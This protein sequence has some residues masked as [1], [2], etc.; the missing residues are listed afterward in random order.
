MT[1]AACAVGPEG[2]VL[3]ADSTSTVSVAK[4]A[5]RY[6]HN[7]QK[8][9][10]VG[11]SS[12]FG[13][14][15]WGLGRIG[16]TSYRTLI[17]QLSDD[18]RRHPPASVEEAAAAFSEKI[19]SVYNATLA[20][21]IRKL[22][23]VIHA[24]NAKPDEA[25]PAKQTLQS[26]SVGFCLGGYSPAN[27]TPGAYQLDF[28]ADL[29]SAPTAK[30][31]PTFGFWGANLVIL[32]TLGFDM[33][34]ADDVLASNK[35]SGT[36]QELHAIFERHRMP[37]LQPVPMRE[38][39]DMIHALLHMTIKVMKFTSVPPVC[40]GHIEIAT[41]TTDRAFRWVKHKSLGAALEHP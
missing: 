8:V 11:E 39:I 23:A 18:F 10:E 9:F 2:I 29:T 25:E 21:E 20:P 15:T 32:R 27:R 1:I 4:S 14:V 40:G 30:P 26:M 33:S 12:S 16:T 17:A 3:G 5:D 13:V 38:T 35:W 31:V 19:W 24:P 41:I 36:A 7:E 22:Q 34:V 28:N 6:L 37:I